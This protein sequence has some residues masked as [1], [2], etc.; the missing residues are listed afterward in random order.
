MNAKEAELEAYLTGNWLSDLANFSAFAFHQLPNLNWAG[1]Y[2][3][4]GK[5]LFLGPF[6][7]KPACTEIA[8]H[9]GVCG[10]AYSK[11]QTLLVPDVHEF[12]GHIACDGASRSEMVLPILAQG[13]CLGVLDLDSPSPGRFQE[14]DRIL[15]EGW[16][17]L[18]LAKCPEL[19]N[20][21][22][23]R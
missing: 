14:S 9:R 11:Q 2:L 6:V 17:A 22:W 21:P 12:P 7:G 18:L 5:K 8:F 23:L 16:L 19:K 10:A 13:K 4:D 15:V 1:F 3:S 20:S